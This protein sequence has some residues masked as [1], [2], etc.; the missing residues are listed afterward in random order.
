MTDQ[1]SKIFIFQ[2]QSYEDDTEIA[3]MTDTSS[4]PEPVPIE[5]TETG[6]PATGRSGKPPTPIPKSFCSI[7]SDDDDDDDAFN[8][9][10]VRN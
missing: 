10:K 9:F 4:K 1:N 3:K 6:Y 5:V 7:D 2:P 8:P